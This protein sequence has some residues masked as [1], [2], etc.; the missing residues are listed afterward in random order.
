MIAA[1]PEDQYQERTY[2]NCRHMWTCRNMKCSTLSMWC[3]LTLAM[4][5]P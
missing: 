2:L 4:V 1:I 3:L 5:L